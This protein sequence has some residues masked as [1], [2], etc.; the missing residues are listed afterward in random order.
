[1]TGLRTA[2]LAATILA[3]PLAAGAQPIQGLYIGAGAG[4][5]YLQQERAQASPGLG[6]TPKRFSTDIGGAGVGSVGY[7]FGN[8][9]RLEIE[10]DVRHNHVRQISGF[11]PNPAT[12]RTGISLHMAA[13]QC[14]VRHGY[15]AE[16]ALSLF[17]PGRRNRG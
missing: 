4:G 3:A 7:G 14:S 10:G 5:N 17:R 15:R 13:W 11:R 2:L 6:L 8:G 16:L 9:L 1:M 12:R